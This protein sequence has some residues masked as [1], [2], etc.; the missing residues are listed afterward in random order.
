MRIPA[1]F[2]NLR[3]D[4]TRQLGLDGTHSC[5]INYLYEL[6]FGLNKAHVNHGSWAR[7]RVGWQIRGIHGAVR[8]A[9]PYDIFGQSDNSTT[10]LSDRAQGCDSKQT[11]EG[12]SL[13][14]PAALR[15]TS[16]R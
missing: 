1:Q 6:P 7:R 15:L 3:A 12:L 13:Y 9:S 14:W 8:A 10:G 11:S 5:V 4:R 16:L 2:F